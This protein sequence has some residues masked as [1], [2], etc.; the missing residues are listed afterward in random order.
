M[1]IH[2]GRRL[3]GVS[4]S[5]PE[6]LGRTG[7]V[8]SLFPREATFSLLGLAPGGV[9]LARLVTQP[10]GALLPHLFTLTATG[11]PIEA[12]SFLWHFP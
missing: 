4:S 3:L 12:V 2:L 8:R 11:E 1:V 9:Y 7:R 6:S 10:A 5:L